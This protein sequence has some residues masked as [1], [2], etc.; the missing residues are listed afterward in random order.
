MTHLDAV[1]LGLIQGLTEFLPVSSSGHLVIARRLL[2]L[3]TGGLIFEVMVH[4]GTALA[5]CYFL[6]RELAEVF[7]GVYRFASA[8]VRGSGGA[9][10]LRTDAGA[11]L[12][13]LVIVSAVPAGLMGVLLGDL[14]DRLFQST[15]VVGLGL[16]GT[17][18]VLHLGQRHAGGDRD[19]LRVGWLDAL[20]VGA[21]QGLAIVPGLSRSGTTV[22]TALTV[23]ISRDTAAKLSF[24]MSIPVIVGASALELVDYV[25]EPVADVSWAHIA[26][27][28]AAAAVSGF[29]AVRTFMKVIQQGRIALF[30]WYCFAAG[31]AVIVMSIV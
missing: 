1:L 15:L 28:A 20:V 11:R 18:L 25:R 16:I 5:V 14:F 29:V 26:M 23:G 4:L 24:L 2:D 30:S 17:G 31:I 21:A 3:E 19:V 8:V 22:A 13:F 10:V 9:G 27:G 7:A 12:G 6:R